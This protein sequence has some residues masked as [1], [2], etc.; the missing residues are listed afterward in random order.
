MYRWFLVAL[1]FITAQGTVAAEEAVPD[2]AKSAS[3]ST[4]PDVI[5]ATPV[6]VTSFWMTGPVGVIAII[7]LVLMILILFQ[8]YML[9]SAIE[10]SG[11]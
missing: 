5:Q 9:R 2:S 1:L 8:L 3:A 4:A 6:I 10:K 7:M 11:G